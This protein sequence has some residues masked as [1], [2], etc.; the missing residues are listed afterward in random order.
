[1]VKLAV[2]IGVAVAGLVASHPV[3]AF[4]E[5]GT[6]NSDLIVDGGY[7]GVIKT[8]EDGHVYLGG[9][10]KYLGPYTGGAV[11]ASKTTGEILT[12]YPKV[13][14]AVTKILTDGS[15][16]W[17]IA[18]SFTKVGDINRVALAHILADGTVDP[19]WDAGIASGLVVTMI[20]DGPTLYIG[21]YFSNIAG[22]FRLNLA[23]LNLT[24]GALNPL[25]TVADGTVTDLEISGT[26]LYVSG[27]FNNLN[28]E[29]RNGL[30]AIDVNTGVTTAWDPNPDGEVKDMLTD[31]FS[32]FVAGLFNNIGGQARDYLAEIDT[33]TGLATSWNP[34]PS[35]E[36]HKLF[37]D[38]TTLYV[39][40]YFYTIGG[41]I[42]PYLAAIDTISGLATAWNP[43]ADFDVNSFILDGT[44]LYVG[45]SFSNIGGAARKYVAALDTV[46]GLA[47]SW[48]P[49]VGDIVYSL[50]LDADKVYIGGSFSSAGG[51]PRNRLARISPDGTID[52]TWNPNADGEVSDLIIDGST[53]Y[54]GG[55]FS[56]I[57]GAPRRSVAALDI[58]TGLVTS[59]NTGPV[60]GF[61]SSLEKSGTVLYLAGGINSINGTPRNNIAAVDTTTGSLLA[62]NPDAD[63]SVNAME[64]KDSIVYAAGLFTNIGGAAR[65]R[66]AAI[67]IST[68][69]ATDWNPDSNASVRD[70][71]VDGDTLYAGGHFTQ[72]GGQPRNHIAAIDLGSGLATAWNPNADQSVDTL[73]VHGATVYASGAFF[74][75]GGQSRS[76]LGAIDKSTGQTTPW[77]PQ[78]N[79]SVLGFG[80]KGTNIYM[81]GFF[82]TV[83]NT[84]ARYFVS[85][86]TP[87]VE[88]TTESGSA[89]ESVT[90]VMAEVSLISPSTQD[91]TVSYDFY[92]SGGGLATKDEDFTSPATEVIVNSGETSAFIPLTIIDDSQVE[93][94]EDIVLQLTAPENAHLGNNIYYTYTILD[95]DEPVPSPS[96][97]PSPTPTSSPTAPPGYTCPV[98]QSCS[99]ACGQMAKDVPN[100]SCGYNHCDPTPACGSSDGSATPS[101]LPG[102]TPS[103]SSIVTTEE[104]PGLV[105]KSQEPEA[106]AAADLSSTPAAV[107]KTIDQKSDQKPDQKVDQRI[108]SGEVLSAIINDVKPVL[109]KAATVVPQTTVALPALA[110]VFVTLQTATTAGVLFQPRLFLKILQAL[111]LFSR[112]NP[113]GIIFDSLTSA[114]IAFGVVRFFNHNKTINDLVVSDINGLY[115][116]VRLPVGEYELSANHKDYRFPSVVKRPPFI[117]ERDFYT[118]GVLGVTKAGAKQLISIPGDRKSKKTQLNLGGYFNLFVLWYLRQS[119]KIYVFFGLTSLILTIINPTLLN[120]II[121]AAYGLFL[122]EKLF[123]YLTKNV[124]K[125]YLAGPAGEPL[126]NA[127][128]KFVNSQTNQL[129]AIVQTNRWGKFSTLIDPGKFQVFIQKVGYVWK[130]ASKLGYDEIDSRQVKSLKYA[131]AVEPESS[132]EALIK[133]IF[134]SK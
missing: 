43:S 77:D 34:A 35:A 116:G 8:A 124:V 49:S 13:N 92:D 33:G 24:T 32:V 69:S 94:P 90:N 51:V 46:T 108:T 60:S 4:G 27:Q 52:E 29:P 74:T 98:A 17:Y 105:E 97:T 70:I 61:I 126:A 95:N 36:A 23:S 9:V 25:Y 3:L 39:S 125:G 115:K 63:D 44:T 82:S 96:P 19:A 122:G 86:S 50:A 111:G 58:S 101:P 37:L 14:G 117:Q 22:T 40:G 42:R 88:L 81:G 68:G 84:F 118:G 76:Y 38:G 89:G 15:G 134:G 100:G 71:V 110:V 7:V 11:P 26:T 99:N 130:E 48:A 104:E 47:T 129:E 119:L 78:V 30:G 53:L 128:V 28:G 6:P 31:G 59:W 65:N 83:F 112:G 91:I 103:P 18:G 123:S 21:G 75:L 113:Q 64:L 12:G 107:V 102:P 62:W 93:N 56:N 121:S 2:I 55:Q 10:F 120:L 79:S 87:T 57:G 72:I 133:Q 5:F 41:Q 131:L 127:I 73:F 20:A 1:M 109:E 80:S 85:I 66:I 114:P 16:G 45:G 106:T 54:V 67:D 132:K